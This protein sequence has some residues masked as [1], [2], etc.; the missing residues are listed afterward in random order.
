[1]EKNNKNIAIV[2]VAVII[3][4]AISMIAWNILTPDKE[5]RVTVVNQ[6]GDR[7]Y[8]YIFVFNNTEGYSDVDVTTNGLEDNDSRSFNYEPLCENFT[9]LVETRTLDDTLISYEFH[10]FFNN[11][12]YDLVVTIQ[13]FGETITITKMI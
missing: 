4:V 1:M 13:D 10:Y 8:V 3:I 5:F 7:L 9:F 2:T 6:S 11:E 12:V